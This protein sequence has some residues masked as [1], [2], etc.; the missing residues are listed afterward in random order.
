MFGCAWTA[1]TGPFTRG[2]IICLYMFAF[3]I[4][5]GSLLSCRL[6]VCL[7]FRC[8][9]VQLAEGSSQASNGIIPE[10][11]V[12]A[13]KVQGPQGQ[14]H[15]QVWSFGPAW[16]VPLRALSSWQ[17]P[18]CPLDIVPPFK[19]D[20]SPRTSCSERGCRYGMTVTLCYQKV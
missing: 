20:Q 18:W 17:C 3:T 14:V 6:L 4:V 5:F 19:S 8:L 1:L 12:R 16:Q 9:H 2:Y 11:P 15:Q 10:L 13:L 7:A